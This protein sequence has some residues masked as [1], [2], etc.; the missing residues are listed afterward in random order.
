MTPGESYVRVKSEDHR[1]G[2]K[3]GPGVG[4]PNSFR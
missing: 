2:Y 3:T 4:G 1:G